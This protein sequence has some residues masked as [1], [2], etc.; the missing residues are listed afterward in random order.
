[1]QGEFSYQIT[2]SSTQVPADSSIIGVIL[3]SDSDSR[4]QPL[5]A[6]EINR[7][8]GPFTRAAFGDILALFS[9]IV[10]LMSMPCTFATHGNFTVLRS[11]C[12]IA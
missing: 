4:N 5:S 11:L 12:Y 10:R 7:S 3:V 1:V 9:A 8:I 6:G 2:I